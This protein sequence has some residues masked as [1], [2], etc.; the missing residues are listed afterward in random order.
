M[1]HDLIRTYDAH[2]RVGEILVVNNA[3]KSLAVDAEK[4][5][6]LDQETNIFVNPAW[7]L[8]AQ[9]ASTTCCCLE[10]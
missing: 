5:R 10:R 1:L 7:N 4:L 6:V 8:G 3:S 9:E 2:P